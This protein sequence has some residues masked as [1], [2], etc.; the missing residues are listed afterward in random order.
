MFLYMKKNTRTHQKLLGVMFLFIYFPESS[1]CDYVTLV[2][3]V[4]FKPLSFLLHH[5]CEEGKYASF[6]FDGASI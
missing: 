4:I 6:Y 3:K 2:I 5:S 1:N